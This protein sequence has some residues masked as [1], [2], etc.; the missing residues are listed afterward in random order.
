MTELQAWLRLERWWGNPALKHDAFALSNGGEGCAFICG[1][2][3]VLFATNR[4]GPVVYD[5]MK[6]KIRDAIRRRTYLAPKTLS[7]AKVRAAFCRKQAR[8]LA[9]KKKKGARK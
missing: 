4:I 7:G 8:L 3:D 5:R 1:D 2:I 6:Q 9:P